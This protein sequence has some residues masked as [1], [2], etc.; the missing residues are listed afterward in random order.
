MSAVRLFAALELPADVVEALVAWRAPLLRA[1]GALRPLAPADLHV[2]LCFLGWQEAG[3]VAAIAAQTRE[4]TQE[5]GPVRRLA[6]AE[7][8]W[9]PSRRPRVLAVRLADPTGALA[10]LQRSLA[11]RLAAGG[12]YQPS[13]RP[14]LPHVTLARLGRG[15]PELG[16][17]TLPAA[18]DRA[19]D[20]RAVTLQRSHLRPAGAR[21]EVLAR[22]GL[23]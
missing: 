14:Y 19:F 21:Y 2:T 9:L 22:T 10:G 4:A 5:V 15:A 16:R 3:M 1:H 7:G 18:P 8:L 17:A 12:W 6:L 20:A 23:A 11:G 13:A